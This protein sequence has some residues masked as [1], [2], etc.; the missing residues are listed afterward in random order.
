MR[1]SYGTPSSSSSSPAGRSVSQSFWLPMMTP[2]SGFGLGRRATMGVLCSRTATRSRD[3]EASAG[4]AGY[5]RQRRG[6]LLHRLLVGQP[7]R[8]LR[9]HLHVEL[10]GRP[11]EGA[12]V[13]VQRLLVL[14]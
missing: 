14:A 10:L 7:L 11:G 3:F 13:Q 2:T 1:A 6:L 9:L 4:P 8:A 5:S 12:R